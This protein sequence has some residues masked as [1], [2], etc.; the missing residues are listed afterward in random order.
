MQAIGVT[1]LPPLQGGTYGLARYAAAAPGRS[2]Y[3]RALVPGSLTTGWVTSMACGETGRPRSARGEEIRSQVM[4]PSDVHA[5]AVQGHR[6]LYGPLE[7]A[8]PGIPVGD[9]PTGMRRRG[10]QLRREAPQ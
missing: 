2:A 9:A 10:R 8:V 5:V 7:L 1:P 3:S 6:G 4:D